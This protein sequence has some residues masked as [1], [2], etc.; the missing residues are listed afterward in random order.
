MEFQT[1]EM[2]LFFIL[3]LSKLCFVSTMILLFLFTRCNHFSIK[4]AKIT[5]YFPQISN[6]F[7]SNASYSIVRFG[8]L[9]LIY[10]Q[11][12]ICFVSNRRTLY[13]FT[14]KV[15][16]RHSFTRKTHYYVVCCVQLIAWM[17]F[18]AS[19]C[20]YPVKKVKRLLFRRFDFNS[21][22]LAWVLEYQ[23]AYSHGLLI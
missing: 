11:Q 18:Y 20:L 22:T 8:Q 7:N 19:K 2:L 12:L 14:S 13:R 17:V 16:S 15:N 23:S 4:Y 6:W 21:M 3:F 1:T 5:R 10:T 9:K